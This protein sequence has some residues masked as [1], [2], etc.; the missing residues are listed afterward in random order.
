MKSRECRR[1][2]KNYDNSR[3]QIK[4]L[5]SHCQSPT[6]HGELSLSLQR[7]FVKMKVICVF[8]FLCNKQHP[9]QGEMSLLNNYKEKSLLLSPSFKVK[10]LSLQFQ[11]NKIFWN[12]LFTQFIQAG[13]FMSQN[14]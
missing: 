14:M 9:N 7:F 1:F 5:K 12:N 11:E 2:S 10:K 3:L 13:C 6:R 8:N 4:Y